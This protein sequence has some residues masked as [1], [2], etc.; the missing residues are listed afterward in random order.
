MIFLISSKQS[1]RTEAAGEVSELNL[2]PSDGRSIIIDM[3]EFDTKRI[4]I[5]TDS[6]FT[7]GKTIELGDLLSSLERTAEHGEL[8]KKLV[9]C[10][11]CAGASMQISC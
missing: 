1:R 4:Y 5:T 10:Q 8:K 3:I 7:A 2:R 11:C 6:I 9:M